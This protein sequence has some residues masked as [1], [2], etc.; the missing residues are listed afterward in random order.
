MKSVMSLVQSHYLKLK[1]ILWKPSVT[2]QENFSGPVRFTQTVNGSVLIRKN[3]LRRKPNI[4][5]KYTLEPNTITILMTS[6]RPQLNGIFSNTTTRTILLKRM[7]DG[8]S[9]EIDSM[10]WLL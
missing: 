6:T 9:K 4:L 5:I 10:S 7:E 3:W 8:S 1:N 2:V